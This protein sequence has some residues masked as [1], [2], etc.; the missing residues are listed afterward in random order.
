MNVLRGIVWAA[1]IA[2][3]LGMV[4]SANTRGARFWILAALA[5]LA[6]AAAGNRDLIGDSSHSILNR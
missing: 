3:F 4:V 6:V 5:I 2:A 1:A